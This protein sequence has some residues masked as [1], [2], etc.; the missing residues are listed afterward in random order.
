M[1]Q[2]GVRVDVASARSP[3]GER[4]K[5]AAALGS[6]SA[7]W[8][9]PRFALCSFAGAL[10]VAVLLGV[11]TAIISTPLFTR[12]TSIEPEQYVFWIATSVLSGALLATY[13]D[14]EIAQKVAGRG[15]GAGFL[16]VFAVGCPICNKLVVGL[17]G[18]SG[19][20]SYFAPVQPLLGMAAVAL[21]S[22]ALWLR[23]RAAS[24]ASC[25]I[26]ASPS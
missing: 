1:E 21:A 25:D 11:P 20:L 10:F 12:M 26:Q 13:L 5:P 22:W 19:A 24:A 2:G 3:G 9:T 15:V 16:G 4:V 7:A 8:L 18:T 23:I 6:S 17:L 14:R